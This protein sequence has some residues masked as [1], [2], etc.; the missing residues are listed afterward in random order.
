[1]IKKVTVQLKIMNKVDLVILAGGKG[2]RIK[3]L[4]ANKPKPMAKFN[5]KFFIEY[6]IQNFSKYDFENIY[7][8]TGYKSKI[9]FKKF[10][11]KKYNFT[12]ITCIKEK[13]PM[14]TGGALYKLK[15]RK[16]N[17][18]VLHFA[19]AVGVSYII[20]NPLKSILINIK[21]TEIILDACSKYNKK[22]LIASTSEVY[23]KQNKNITFNEKSNVI[24]G[25]PTIG[26]WSYAAGKLIDEFLSLA[27]FKEKNL[28]VVIVRFFNVVGPEQ[29]SNYGMV[30]PRLIEQAIKNKPLT[31]FGSGKQTRTFSYIDDINQYLYKLIF[32][33]KNAFGQIFNLGGKEN[34]SI[35]NLAKKIIKISKSKSTIKRINYQKAFKNNYEDMLARKPDLE[36]IYNFTKYKPIYNLDDMLKKIIKVKKLQ[37]K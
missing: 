23:G 4:L 37:N 36:K 10:H 5:K 16:K 30:V 15:H 27:Y 1:M 29:L 21:G 12:N 13:K 24:Y 2:T 19:A 32:S 3:R 18:F 22:I 14:G 33:K 7:I 25:P 20:D 6:I 9:I 17:D 11:N 8:L 28:K 31:V 34:I 26:R 35:N